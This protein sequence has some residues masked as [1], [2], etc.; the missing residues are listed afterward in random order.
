[1][2]M[3]RYFN[4]VNEIF[5]DVMNVY[6][7]PR[8]IFGP[9]HFFFRVVSCLFVVENSIRTFH[10]FPLCGETGLYLAR[11]ADRLGVAL[12]AGQVGDRKPGCA[13][14]LTVSCCLRQPRITSGGTRTP[15]RV[16]GC[17]SLM[18]HQ[19]RRSSRAV[20]H[21]RLIYQGTLNFLCRLPCATD[22]LVRPCRDSMGNPIL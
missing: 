10:R 6:S 16:M 9:I 3:T 15:L 18:L 1:M 22:R 19:H 12:T 20:A 11:R 5:A 13:I 4:G 7:Y 17:L 8:I 14:V 21:G 2:R